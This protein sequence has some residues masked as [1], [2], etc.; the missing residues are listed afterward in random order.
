MT[1]ASRGLY[2]AALVAS[3]GAGFGMARWTG[4]TAV[5]TDAEL[6][7]RLEGVE[8]ELR[9]LRQGLEGPSR[10]APVAVA[11]LDARALQEDLRRMVREEFQTVTAEARAESP[12]DRPEPAPP[13]P[14]GNLEAYAKARRVLED[15]IASRHWG[16]QERG[17][18]RALREKLTQPQLRELLT[19]LAVAINQQQLRI[20]THG[21]PF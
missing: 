15:G 8:R 11:G 16:D 14:S 21:P 18:L 9:A 20:T 4:P 6:P 12:P 2:L 1:M 7:R 5:A 17:E 19:K 3:A 13:I 10:P